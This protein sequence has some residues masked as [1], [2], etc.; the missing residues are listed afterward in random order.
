MK[1]FNVFSKS[2]FKLWDVVI[3][4][5]RASNHHSKMLKH[6]VL[7]AQEQIRANKIRR[8]LFNNFFMSKEWRLLET[9]KRCSRKWKWIQAFKRM[10]T[11]VL[12]F[13]LICYFRGRCFA[14]VIAHLY[15]ERRLKYDSFLW[16]L[17]RKLLNVNPHPQTENVSDIGPLG[18][19][20]K[21]MW[22]QITDPS[23]QQQK[24][25]F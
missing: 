18:K 4:A 24:M 3:C 7:F 8:S 19:T 5:K 23:T 20:I 25:R 16:P 6:T 11:K 9:R 14:V 22:P 15:R 12:Y 10:K 17:S 1:N 13:N 2:R 21:E